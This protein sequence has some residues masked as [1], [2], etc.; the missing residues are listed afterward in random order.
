MISLRLSEEEYA[1][2]RTRCSSYGAGN[3]SDLARLALHRVIAESPVSEAELLAKVNEL[4]HRVG[5]VERHLSLLLELEKLIAGETDVVKPLLPQRGPQAPHT[6]FAC[7]EE[8]RPA[9]AAAAN[10]M[11]IH[12]SD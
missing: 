9:L 10:E 8:A 2:L 11:S 12:E 7:P 6:L 3:V 4:D 1:A 5:A